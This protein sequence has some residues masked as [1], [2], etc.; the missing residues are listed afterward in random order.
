MNRSFSPEITFVPAKVYLATK[1]ELA[2][3]IATVATS[4]LLHIVGMLTM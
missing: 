3:G 1:Y 4:G 2:Y